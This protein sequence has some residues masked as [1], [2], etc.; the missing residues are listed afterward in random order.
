M[1]LTQSGREPCCTPSSDPQ[2]QPA[3]LALQR[4]PV[5]VGDFFRTSQATED[6]KD[7]W[8]AEP[9]IVDKLGASVW[10]LAHPLIYG[11]FKRLHERMER[12]RLTAQTVTGRCGVGY[13]MIWSDTAYCM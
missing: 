2:T 6:S 7:F 3:T 9:C 13:V 11:A 12:I 8:L 1:F 4:L 10:V 5:T